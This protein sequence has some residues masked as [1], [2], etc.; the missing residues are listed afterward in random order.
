MESHINELISTYKNKAV[1]FDDFI[2]GIY[3]FSDEQKKLIFNF[4][5]FI[6]MDKKWIPLTEEFIFEYLIPND[7]RHHRNLET[8]ENFYTKVLA[9][10][11]KGQYKS[12]EET[13]QLLKLYDKYRITRF[14]DNGGNIANKLSSKNYAITITSFKDLL[15]NS[16]VKDI[17]SFR[18]YFMK[19]DTLFH[20]YENYIS[21]LH[22]KKLT[23]KVETLEIKEKSLALV[24]CAPQS[25]RSSGNTA[26]KRQSLQP[27]IVHEYI[28]ISATIENIDKN[29]F[30]IGRI[31]DNNNMAIKV[32]NEN[33]MGI[34]NT[35]D[36]ESVEVYIRSLLRNICSDTDDGKFYV[37]KFSV[38]YNI[39]NHICLN[40]QNNVSKFRSVM[41]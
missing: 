18:N 2:K 30:K 33:I 32:D 19:L 36:G 3:I 8:I 39:I 1:S 5:V 21:K 10:E 35:T 14:G 16:P 11:C 20:G 41:I 37:C 17:A 12:I 22:I 13:D 28:Y 4:W 27:Q 15:I 29:M 38:L 7:G 6:F 31:L 24:S 23:D 25:P 26:T 34:F 40:H 9:V